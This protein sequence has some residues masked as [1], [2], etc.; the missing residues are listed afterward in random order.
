MDGRVASEFVDHDTK[1]VFSLA[2]EQS[3]KE[4]FR[5]ALITARLNQDTQDRTSDTTVESF[6]KETMM[7]ARRED[8]RH[9]GS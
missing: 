3:A 4:P 6:H 9:R 1:W 2:V 5:G 8:P 7:P